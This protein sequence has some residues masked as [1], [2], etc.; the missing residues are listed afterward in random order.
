MI[1]TPPRLT[2]AD[3]LCRYTTLFRSHSAAARATAAGMAASGSWPARQA[4]RKAW[5]GREHVLDISRRRMEGLRRGL[6]VGHDGAGLD[7]ERGAEQEE[8]GHR[9]NL[10][11]PDRRH[12]QPLGVP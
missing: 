8:A 11:N 6:H 7:G 10:D 4:F 12:M 5:G 3:T 2:L 9:R 1:R